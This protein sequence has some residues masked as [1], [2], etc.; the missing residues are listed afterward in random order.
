MRAPADMAAV[1][2]ATAAGDVRE[3]DM[4]RAALERKAR[5]AG[6]HVSDAMSALDLF[7][8]LNHLNAYVKAKAAGRALGAEPSAAGDNNSG[9]DSDVD[10]VSLAEAPPAAQPAA[11]AE[12][13]SDDEDIDGVPLALPPPPRPQLPAP[14]PPPPAAAAAAAAAAKGKGEKRA[15]SKSASSDG[16]DADRPAAE[17]DLGG[18]KKSRWD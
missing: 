15:R 1:E 3:E 10:G 11:A 16:S 4:D 5:Q 17:P 18:L 14:P 13:S 9:S 7:N 6:L 2:G 8:R 12:S